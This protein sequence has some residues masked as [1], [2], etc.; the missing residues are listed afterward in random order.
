LGDGGSWIAAAEEC[1]H[2]PDLDSKANCD[3]KSQL[4]HQSKKYR[5]YAP[6]IAE[7][8]TLARGW[9]SSPKP[10]NVYIFAER[11]PVTALDRAERPC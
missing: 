4:A 1:I 10:N 6:D 8:F 9:R 7:I 11:A 5:L 2:F 3:E